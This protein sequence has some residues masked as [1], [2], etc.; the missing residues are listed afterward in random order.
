MEL[1]ATGDGVHLTVTLD[2]MHDDVWTARS[3]AG[4]ESQLEKLEKLLGSR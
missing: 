4:W 2:A 3:V 1:E